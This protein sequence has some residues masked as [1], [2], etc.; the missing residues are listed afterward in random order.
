MFKSKLYALVAM[1]AFALVPAVAHAVPTLSFDGANGTYGNAPG[2]IIDFKD[3]YSFS[4]PT[5]GLLSITLSSTKT[6]PYT[7]VNFA[8]N[9]QFLN[10]TI[11]FEVVTSGTNEL[12]RLLNIPVSAGL[13]TFSI[14]GSSQTN[15][16][17]SGTLSFMSAVPEPATWVMLG[18]GFGGIALTLRRRRNTPARVRL[19]YS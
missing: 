6:G 1:S 19:A 16:T 12:R 18:L 17:Y 13:Q 10:G 4:V 7:N 15:G 3:V 14:I 11:P 2:S 9:G 8:T 5:A